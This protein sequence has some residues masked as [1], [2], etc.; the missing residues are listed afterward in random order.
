MGNTDNPIMETSNV[1][2]NLPK[3]KNRTTLFLLICSLL[4]IIFG[5]VYVLNKDN[6]NKTENTRSN[7]NTLSVLE[8]IK[9]L[10]DM[11]KYDDD[12][13]LDFIQIKSNSR[14]SIKIVGHKVLQNENISTIAAKY[15]CSNEEIVKWNT[16]LVKDNNQINIGTTL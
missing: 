5:V 9:S 6:E 14:S 4:G 10:P 16:N 2:D 15:K 7:T 12:L 13:L 11:E 3:K 8:I 1:S